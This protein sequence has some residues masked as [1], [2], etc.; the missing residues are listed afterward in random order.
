MNSTQS[1]KD[2]NGSSTHEM[3]KGQ[4]LDDPYVWDTSDEDH[5]TGYYDFTKDE[6]V[7]LIGLQQREY[8]NLIGQVK[9]V[10]SESN[11]VYVWTRLYGIKRFK[12]QNVQRVFS[13]SESETNEDDEPRKARRRKIGELLSNTTAREIFRA[14]EQGREIDLIEKDQKLKRMIHEQRRKDWMDRVTKLKK[15]DNLQEPTPLVKRLLADVEQKLRISDPDRFRLYN[16]S[17]FDTI[18]VPNHTKINEE[19]VYDYMCELEENFDYDKVDNEYQQAAR[20]E[21]RR[22]YRAKLA[23]E[24][25]TEMGESV[26]AFKE[27][28]TSLSRLMRGS[29]NSSSSSSA[30]GTAPIRIDLDNFRT[31]IPIRSTHSS[32]DEERKVPPPNSARMMGPGEREFLRYAN[33]PRESSSSSIDE[34]KYK[35]LGMI[36]DNFIRRNE[37]MPTPREAIDEYMNLTSDLER[38]E[39]EPS[40]FYE[41]NQSLDEYID[42]NLFYFGHRATAESL[43][44]GMAEATGIGE[45]LGGKSGGTMDPIDHYHRDHYY[46]H[47]KKNRGKNRP[48]RSKNGGEGEDEDEGEEEGGNHPLHEFSDHGDPYGDFSP[49]DLDK[50]MEFFDG[51]DE[52]QE[53]GEKMMRG[54]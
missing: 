25:Y 29:R 45:N 40:Y 41:T 12:P 50:P 43:Q 7:R 18:H 44:A 27:N 14:E 1:Q 53:Y 15:D 42:N 52:A 20:A 21:R 28:R 22:I 26:S 49:S 31:G 35:E 37:T 30:N 36:R 9:G 34:T 38:D 23:G 6:K 4:D 51:F 3:T 39:L 5:E 10:D 13:D 11:R 8:N 2:G 32:S 47:R 48:K 16:R 33:E 24:K 54:R 46:R 19:Y 17:I